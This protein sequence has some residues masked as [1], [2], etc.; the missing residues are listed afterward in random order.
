MLAG[1]MAL[2]LQ[3]S[4]GKILTQHI[5]LWQFQTLRAALNVLFVLLLARVTMRG[6]RLLPRNGFPVFIRS[7]LHVAALMCF[8]GSAPF[9]TMAEMAGGLYTFPLF[10][11]ALSA[12]FLRERVGIRRIMAILVGFL[13]TLLI[14]RPGT[15]S[16]RLVGLL[17][18][19]AGFS[20]AVFI[21]V[22]RRFCKAESPVVLT[23]LSNITIFIFGLIGFCTVIL[24]QPSQM[25]KASYPFIMTAWLP[26][27]PWMVVV[28]TIC[29]L[30]NVIGNISMS[31]AYQSAESSF[32]APFDYSYLVF[33]TFWGFIFWQDIP[34]PMTIAGMM[35]IAASG[36]FVAWR[37]RQQRE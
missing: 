4:L 21:I 26:M 33:A 13:G 2:S 10:V 18:V 31:K 36:I 14:L 6:F 3:D 30:F 23:L 19:C 22:T 11:A 29:T 20:Y 17:P 7:L 32:L 27:L 35:I 28:L 8:F 9:L 37:E 16:F 25:L 12:L 5:S 34:P 24:L 1:L 15:D